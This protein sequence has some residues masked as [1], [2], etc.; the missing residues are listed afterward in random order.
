MSFLKT[1]IAFLKGVGPTR[2]ERLAKELNVK[3]VEDL[4]SVYPFR[5]IDKTKFQKIADLR[6]A[7]DVA[8]IKGK[9]RSIEKVQSANRQSRLTALLLD[10][11]GAIEL[12]W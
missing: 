5:Y 11:T 8:L 3:T 4:I 10:D 7:D 6:T 9:I 12:V 2:A 1:D